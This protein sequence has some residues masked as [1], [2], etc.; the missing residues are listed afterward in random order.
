MPSRNERAYDACINL[1]FYPNAARDLGLRV[2]VV[3]A[4][5]QS[6]I[7]PAF[8]KMAE[9]QVGAVVVTQDPLFLSYIDQVA[10][11]A[12]HHVIPAVFPDRE[13]VKAGGLLSYVPDGPDLVRQVGAYAGRILKG[14]KPADLPVQRPTKFE[15]VINLKTARALGL[16]ISKRLLVRAD[17]VIE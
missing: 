8:A 13:A 3:N 2:E 15:F 1:T 16:T 9:Q 12:V 10:A 5:R 6:D 17:E 4:S 11:P 14:E 7:E